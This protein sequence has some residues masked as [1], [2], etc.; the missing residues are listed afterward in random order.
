MQPERPCYVERAADRRLDEALRAKRLCCV[1][2]A[3]GIGKSSLLL[4]AARSLRAAGTLVAKVD[5][6]RMAELGE[7]DTEGDW[8]RRVAQRVAEQLELGVD[9]GQ[10]WD[11]HDVLGENRLVSFFWE[12]VL[13][14][15]TAPVVVLVDDVDVVLERSLGADFLEAIGECYERRERERDFAR[16]SFALAGCAS[17]RALAGASGDTPFAKAEVIE[18]ADFT[19]EQSYR[20][21][22][23]FGGQQE[24]AQAL[25]D[26]ICVWT[27]GQPYLTQR[28]ARSV[29]RKGGRL[30][31]VERVVREQLLAPGAAD[32]DPLLSQV[33]VWLGEPSRPA[34]RATR[35][36]QKLSAG[37]KVAQPAE[38]AVWERLWL[39]GVASVDDANQ[40]RVRNRVIK[41]LVAA[42]WLNP[43]SSGWRWAA[44]AAVL[45]AALAAGG[46]WYTQRLPVG[47]IDT[48]TSATAEPSAVEDAYRRLRNLPGFAERAD[49]LWLEALGRQSRAATTLSSAMAADT[50]MRELPEQDT[51]ADGL[52]GE[53]W[54][55]RAREQA[56]AEQRG[57]ALLLAQR[58]AQ[59]PAA[60]PA[61]A[62][63]LSELVGDDYARLERSLRIAG[64]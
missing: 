20:L 11:A 63:Y 53:F 35:L 51:A 49:E 50:R 17:Q 39:A 54:L 62:A 2:G 28:V 14:N 47:D 38:P 26:R 34:R 42:R 7:G 5:L 59:L 52:L 58:A 31:D 40:L 19:A 41:E 23:A 10:W 60:E 21:A 37:G 24:L 32:R 25:M 18:P 30:E 33:R 64:T 12:V 44:A 27:G 9:A 1:L 55:R 57:A 48:L 4:R 8:L 15:T 46:Y 29:A 13:T 3:H 56:H 45:L 61:A 43:A 6:R 36:L 22:V 16:L